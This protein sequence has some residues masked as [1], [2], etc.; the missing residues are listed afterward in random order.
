MR[1]G[2]IVKDPSDG[3]TDVDGDGELGRRIFEAPLNH[4]YNW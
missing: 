4:V 3:V 2:R 1:H